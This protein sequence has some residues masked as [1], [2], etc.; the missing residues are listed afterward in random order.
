[1]IKRTIMFHLAAWLSTVVAIC[2]S[3]A[4]QAQTQG[5]KMYRVGFLGTASAAGYVREIEWIRA[6][7]RKAGYE[8]GRNLALELRWGEGSAERAREIAAEFVA[9]RVDAIL[10]HGIPGA[11]AASRV[12]SSIP[13][14]MADGAD[15]VASGLAVSLARPGRNVTGS[16]SFVP[17]DSAK[18]LEL[19]REVFPRVRRV[20]FLRSGMPPPSYPATSKALQAA[21]ASA[22]V[23]L[24]EFT[25]AEGGELP[26]VFRAMAAARI[27]ALVVNN[28]P[29]LNAQ[30]SVIAALAS[31]TRLPAIG[32]PSFADHGGLLAYG[33]NRAALYQRA[34]YFLDRIFKGARPADIPFEQAASFELIVNMKT[35][36]ALGVTIPQEVRVRAERIVE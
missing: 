27:E 13:I 17:E 14:V 33:S 5:A 23:E 9:L 28:E 29:Q 1:M 26:E 8:E 11:L 4:L 18:R 24:V 36:R 10:V 15:P 7:L 19:L 3:P 12:T 6:G 35:A 31:V 2:L 20:G 16:T 22:K 21:A 34:G 25:A 32:Y 30:A